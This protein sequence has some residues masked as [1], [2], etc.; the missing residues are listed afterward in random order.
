[1]QRTKLGEL[2]KKKKQVEAKLEFKLKHFRG[3]PHESAS[4]ELAYSDIKV[5]ED[6]LESIKVEIASLTRIKK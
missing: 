4:G 1:M 3:V 5:L 2:L 6:F